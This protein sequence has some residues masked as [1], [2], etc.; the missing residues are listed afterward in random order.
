[1]MAFPELTS[2]TLQS[3]MRVHD[4]GIGNLR[5]TKDSSG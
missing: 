2:E 3:P 1:L 5:L 4:C